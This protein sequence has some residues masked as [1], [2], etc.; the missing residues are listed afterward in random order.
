MIQKP[1][2]LKNQQKKVELEAERYIYLK[3]EKFRLVGDVCLTE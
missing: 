1:W 2:S 3:E